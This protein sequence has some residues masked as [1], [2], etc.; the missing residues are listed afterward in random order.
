MNDPYSGPTNKDIMTPELISKTIKAALQRWSFVADLVFTELKEGEA[1]IMIKFTAG[2]HG[3]AFSF[4]GRGQALAHAFYPNQN[5]GK[6]V[7]LSKRV[8]ALQSQTLMTKT[9]QCKPTFRKYEKP[10]I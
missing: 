1:D 6:S 4:D 2:E 3:D 5:T 8:T 10:H 9:S 7:R